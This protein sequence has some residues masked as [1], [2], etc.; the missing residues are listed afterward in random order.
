M[1]QPSTA[2]L[3]Q[4]THPAR[5]ATSVSPPNVLS[6]KISIH[7]PRERCDRRAVPV[8]LSATYFNPRTPREVRHICLPPF[9]MPVTFQSTHPA[10]GA[11]GINIWDSNGHMISIHAPRERCDSGM[12]RDCSAARISIH[13]PRERCDACGPYTRR[14]ALH[15]NPRTPREVRRICPTTSN[16][17]V[18]ISIHA[19]RE[20]CDFPAVYLRA[21]QPDF[22]PRTPREVRPLNL[23]PREFTNLFQ[24]T[25]PARGATSQPLMLFLYGAISIHAP[26]ERCDDEVVAVLSAISISIHAPRE[27]CDV[28][29]LFG[30]VQYTGFQSTHPARGAT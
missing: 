5:G 2:H 14:A 24:S 1:R 25:H 30:G 12:C 21:G 4:S 13:A 18:F 3:F 22:N 9:V 11:T 16:L 23:H 8:P 19:P 7:A 15:F 20:R 6:R 17:S 28:E 29:N 26:R 10:R 27:R